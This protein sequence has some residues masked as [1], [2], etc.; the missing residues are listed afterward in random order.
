[1]LEASQDLRGGAREQQAQVL[2]VGRGVKWRQHDPFERCVRGY[3][4]V[5]PRRPQQEYACRDFFVS[6]LCDCAERAFVGAIKILEHEDES[7]GPTHLRQQTADGATNMGCRHHSHD[8]L[9]PRGGFSGEPPEFRDEPAQQLSV[10]G[11]IGRDR[12]PKLI[13][14]DTRTVDGAAGQLSERLAQD[15]VRRES[16]ELAAAAVRNGRV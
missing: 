6:Q 16:F 2:A 10:F 7:T 1:L 14:E 15:R 8:V 11:E 4:C 9:V 3:P 5:G 13:V 12:A